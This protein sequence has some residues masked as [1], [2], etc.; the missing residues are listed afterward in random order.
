MSGAVH[1]LPLAQRP[2][3]KVRLQQLA[4]QLTPLLDDRV[5]QLIMRQR[6]AA[7]R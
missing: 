6:R 5:L 2:Q 1:L 4:L 3:V 7:Q